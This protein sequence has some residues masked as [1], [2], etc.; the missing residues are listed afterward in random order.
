MRD[1][2]TSIAFMVDGG[3]ASILACTVHTR[4]QS[5]QGRTSN[6]WTSL[7]P[8]HVAASMQAHVIGSLPRASEA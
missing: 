5:S 3:D 2:R 1:P 4:G 7:P 8:L 6:D